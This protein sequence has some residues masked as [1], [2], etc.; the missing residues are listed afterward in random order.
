MNEALTIP[1]G[2]T[3][4]GGIAVDSEG[5]IDVCEVGRKIPEGYFG[6]K[7]YRRIG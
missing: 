1:D 7:K 6:L 2:T 4:T 5:S 3:K